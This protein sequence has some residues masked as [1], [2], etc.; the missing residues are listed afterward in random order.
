MSKGNSGDTISLS[1]AE[2]LRRERVLFDTIKDIL[3]YTTPIPDKDS[4][5]V[6]NCALSRARAIIA[7]RD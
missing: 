4:S 6:T 3:R 5:Y 1:K 2:L 7:E